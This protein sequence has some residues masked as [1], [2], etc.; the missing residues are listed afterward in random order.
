M[1]LFLLIASAALAPLYAASGEADSDRTLPVDD[2]Q[3]W[4]VGFQV[5]DASDDLSAENLYLTRS[6]PLLFKERLGAISTHQLTES[7]RRAYSRQLL[8][9]ARVAAGEKLNAAL[10]ARD[11]I[12][13]GTQKLPQKKTSYRNA[14][15]SVEGAR[16][17]LTFLTAARP[18]D[19]KVAEQKKVEYR[20]GEQELV[21]KAD[22][23]AVAAERDDLDI[24]ISGSIAENDQF[25]FVQVEVYGRFQDE[26]VYRE[27]LAMR[28]EDV[29]A[30]IAPL[31]DDI[32][33]IM[34]GREWATLTV[35]SNPADGAI[36]IDNVLRGFG[37]VTVSYLKPGFHTVTASREGSPD[38]TEQVTLAPQETRQVSLSFFLPHAA[39]V[40]IQS[41]PEGADVYVD[42]VWRGTTPL[43]LPRP[44]TEKNLVLRRDGYL[45]TKV[46]FSPDSPDLVSRKM[47]PD[48]IDWG[49]RIESRRDSFYR[50]L[51]LFALSLPI[52]IIINGVYQNIATL[53]ADGTPPGLDPGSS[54]RLLGTANVLYWSYWGSVGVS[55][56]LLVNMIVK[57]VKYVRSS[58]YANYR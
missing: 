13:F 57:L 16:R 28:P 15:E 27:S 29:D 40:A 20:A 52:P 46:V 58:E 2:R 51:G 19:V 14:E 35:K 54:S 37:S 17:R 49:G 45:D 55:G 8:Q 3:T 33:T 56:G 36:M 9:D 22:P 34:L 24:L 47:L 48:V 23:V 41:E 7:E 10:A 50:S 6:V 18:E 38:V 25:V 53:Y 21:A 44:D 4:R 1:M 5:F 30:G 12:L 43:T 32:A 42:S 26:M 11:E 31:V 39:R